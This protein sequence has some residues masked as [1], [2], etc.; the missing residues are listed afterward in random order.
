MQSESAGCKWMDGSETSLVSHTRQKDSHPGRGIPVLLDPGP[1]RAGVQVESESRERTVSDMSLWLQLQSEG[2][3][4]QGGGGGCGD[5]SAKKKKRLCRLILSSS[6]SGRRVRLPG[7]SSCPRRFRQV[8][9][10]GPSRPVHLPA[11]HISS[12]CDL[13]KRERHEM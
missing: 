4:E 6:H 1:R 7:G 5:G 8:L 13:R 12:T 10:A 11:S 3:G 9:S 2:H